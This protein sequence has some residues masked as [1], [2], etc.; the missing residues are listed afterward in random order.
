[1]PSAHLPSVAPSRYVPVGAPKQLLLYNYE[2][3]SLAAARRLDAPRPILGES[4]SRRDVV[5]LRD[6]YNTLASRTQL[7]RA[8]SGNSWADAL[9]FG[10]PS[11]IKM[12][13]LWNE[14][15]REYLMVANN[16]DDETLVVNFN[17]WFSDSAYRHKL[18]DA[19]MASGDPN[20]NREAVA[21]FG[22][23]SS[24]DELR[25]DG[26]ASKMRVLERWKAC[27]DDALFRSALQSSEELHRHAWIIFGDVFG[28][29]GP[30][31]WLS[32]LTVAAR[33]ER[34]DYKPSPS[35]RALGPEQQL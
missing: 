30:P 4:K 25:M 14:L 11:G 3:C 31:D 23:G 15:A 20:L 19:L 16:P 34:L 33:N 10:D 1:M 6:P 12:A 2:D 21:P 35:Y 13:A 27:L 29:C 26:A 32:A 24:F 8:K 17:K 9:A 7:L 28:E 22:F 18:A 5:I